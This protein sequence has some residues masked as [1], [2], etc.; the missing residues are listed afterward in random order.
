MQAHT[1]TAINRE[2]HSNNSQIHFPMLI[3]LHIVGHVDWCMYMG[4]C[5]VHM[6]GQLSFLIGFIH[7]RSYNSCHFI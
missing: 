5:I 7:I 3:F 2:T 6:N 1:E 4:V